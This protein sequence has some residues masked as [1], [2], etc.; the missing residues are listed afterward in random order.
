MLATP[1]VCGISS[2]CINPEFLKILLKAS[3]Y[4]KTDALSLR[5]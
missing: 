3:P 1:K 2:T 5:Y 4:G